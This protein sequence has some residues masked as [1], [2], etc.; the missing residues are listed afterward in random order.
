MS[1]AVSTLMKNLYLVTIVSKAAASTGGFVKTLPDYQGNAKTNKR[2]ETTK[3][4][5]LKR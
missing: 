3:E 4:E 1:K 5:N 2:I